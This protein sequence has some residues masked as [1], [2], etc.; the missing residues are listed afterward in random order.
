MRR[1]YIPN[2][3]GHDF[4]PAEKFGRL[5]FLSKGKWREKFDVNKIYRQFV[6]AMSTSEA[7]DYLV[8]TGLPI[9]NIIAAAILARKH[10]RLNLLLF[11]GD[12]RYLERTVNIDVL[13]NG[14]SK[15]EN[16]NGTETL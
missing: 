4:S 8:M 16:R 10:G 5:C 6:E 7:E 1:V 9:M 2:K 3:S 14:K 13:L 12:G 11:R 15:K